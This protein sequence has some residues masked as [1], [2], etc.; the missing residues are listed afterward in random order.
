[1]NTAKRIVPG[2]YRLKRS[3]YTYCNGRVDAE[4]LLFVIE[5][6]ERQL[7]FIDEDGTMKTAGFIESEAEFRWSELL[8]HVGVKEDSV[9]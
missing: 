7:R 9:G 5:Y 8:Q 2:L 6:R 3:I 4:T 1:M